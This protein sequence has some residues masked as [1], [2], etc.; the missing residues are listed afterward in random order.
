MKIA[1]F[2]LLIPVIAVMA[3]SP[4]HVI[5]GSVHEGA[6]GPVTIRFNVS[7]IKNAPYSADAETTTTQILADGNRIEHRTTQKLY[8]DSDGRERH[9]ESVLA[10]GALLT[11][12]EAPRVIT[13]SDPVANVSYSLD[14]QTRTARQTGSR[15]T[16][17][18]T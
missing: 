7:P 11:Q 1:L 9:E 12:T 8:R 5:A 3:Q 2:Y 16:V 17:N 14:P 6:G 15:V 10:I 13:I 18:E 4:D